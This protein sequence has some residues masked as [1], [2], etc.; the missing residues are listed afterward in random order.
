MPQFTLSV[1]KSHLKQ[2]AK[3]KKGQQLNTFYR[4]SSVAINLH[5]T[6][7]LNHWTPTAVVLWNTLRVV[8]FS[9]SLQNARKVCLWKHTFFTDMQLYIATKTT[10]GGKMQL[11]LP[12][13]TQSGEEIN[14]YTWQ[15]P[16]LFPSQVLVISWKICSLLKLKFSFRALEVWEF[17]LGFYGLFFFRIKNSIT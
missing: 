11:V 15:S 17:L 12:T 13:T 3:L 7:S 9:D 1:K 14:W 8:L 5:R 10:S 4:T 16:A 6:P 2:H